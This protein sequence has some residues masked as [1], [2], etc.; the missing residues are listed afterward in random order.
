[1]NYSKFNVKESITLQVSNDTGR[2]DVAQIKK[3][4]KSSKK[5]I[6]SRV[7]IASY[8]KAQSKNIETTETKAE[9]WIK[10]D[11]KQETAITK[12]S[13]TIADS[14]KTGARVKTLTAGNWLPLTPIDTLTTN[15]NK[16][17]ASFPPIAAKQ[18]MI[19]MLKESEIDGK[20]TGVLVPN[21]V[22]VDDYV[23]LTTTQQACHLS[24]AIADEAPFWNYAGVLPTEGVYVEGFTHAANRYLEDNP[25]KMEI[26]L[27][28]RTANSTQVQFLDFDITQKPEEEKQ[29]IKKKMVLTEREQQETPFILINEERPNANKGRS[30]SPD[31]Q[32]AQQFTALPIGQKLSAVKL[33]MSAIGKQ[34]VQ[35]QLSLH[36]DYFGKPASDP[37]ASTALTSCDVNPEN[38]KYWVRFEWSEPFELS[39]AQNWWLVLSVPQGELIWYQTGNKPANVQA[40][41]YRSILGS[42]LPLNKP[43]TYSLTTDWLLSQ[44]Y[45]IKP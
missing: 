30:C 18:L 41:L 15:N 38:G 1:M 4:L 19:E 22:K 9:N 8:S 37:L 20:K 23:T 44:L 45:F 43:E 3:E 5:I 14:G 33:G 40:S 28:L 7:I 12:L 35:G 24:M 16:I 26:P 10:V 2:V 34:P 11:F 31:Y 13:M 36:A 25:D 39:Q 17:E 6:E 32:A 21:A 42:W 29:Q 27:T